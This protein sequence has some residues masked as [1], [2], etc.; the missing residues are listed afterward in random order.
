MDGASTQAVEFS[1]GKAVV[2]AILAAI[3]NFVIVVP[4]GALIGG[5]FS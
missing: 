2:T 3:A 5:L 1:N 4:I